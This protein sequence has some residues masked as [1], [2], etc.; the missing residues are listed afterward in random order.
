MPE[1]E[2]RNE[3]KTSN[4]IFRFASEKDSY[5]A[6]ATAALKGIPERWEY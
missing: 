5:V 2:M 6:A 1:F 3:G 4:D